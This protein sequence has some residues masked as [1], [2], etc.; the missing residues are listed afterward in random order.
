[1]KN[2]DKRMKEKCREDLQGEKEGRLCVLQDMDGVRCLGGRQHLFTSCCQGTLFY[3]R[4]SG[5]STVL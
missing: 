2:L 5:G 1:M 4:S 3:P